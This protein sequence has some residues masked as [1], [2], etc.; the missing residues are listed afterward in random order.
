MIA[1]Q[2]LIVE[3]KGQRT[4]L[5]CWLESLPL[6]RIRAAPSR[7]NNLSLMFIAS[8]CERV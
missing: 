8:E 3:S 7:R 6:L 5:A 2:L 4:R 1:T